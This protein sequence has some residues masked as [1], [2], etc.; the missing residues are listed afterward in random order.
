[1][2]LEYDLILFDFDGVISNSLD[3]AINGINIIGR[4]YNL[5]QIRSKEDMDKLYDKELSNSLL[6]YGLKKDEI[7][8]FFKEHARFMQKNSLNIKPFED[9]LRSIK[10]TSARRALVTSS[11]LEA[12]N[13]I[14]GSEI[15]NRE[16]F[17]VRIGKEYPETKTQKIKRVL[18][19]LNVKMQKSLYI[20]DMASD[21]LYCHALPIHILAVGYGYQTSSFLRTFN[22]EY[23]VENTKTLAQILENG[24]L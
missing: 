24:R 18:E 10:K 14:I 12:V 11:Y 7:K 4:K 20:G 6:K 13:Q 5:P 2:T 3:M 8:N 21:I 23:L 22:P 16:L 9:V 15:D 1:M 19:M 17:E